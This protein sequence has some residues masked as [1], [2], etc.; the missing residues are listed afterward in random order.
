MKKDRNKTGSLFS[1]YQNT[2]ACNVVNGKVYFGMLFVVCRYFG[3]VHTMGR[4]VKFS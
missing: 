2:K 1:F 4:E 3:Y